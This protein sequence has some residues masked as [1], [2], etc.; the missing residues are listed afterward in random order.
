MNFSSRKL[1]IAILLHQLFSFYHHRFFFHLRIIIKYNFILTDAAIKSHFNKHLANA[2][3]LCEYWPLI[4]VELRFFF[5]MKFNKNQIKWW[6][7]IKALFLKIVHYYL[8]AYLY[9]PCC[10][11]HL[12]PFYTTNDD[13]FLIVVQKPPVKPS[14]RGRE[15]LHIFNV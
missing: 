10:I 1:E 2:F 11:F 6:Q 14:T 4:E 13:C 5:G 3:I 9:M 15:M 7:T 12:I 8:F